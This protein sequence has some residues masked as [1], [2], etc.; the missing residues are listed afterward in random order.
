[1][2]R[3]ILFAAGLALGAPFLGRRAARA[4]AEAEAQ[5]VDVLLVLAVDVSRSI[6]EEEARLQREGYA[7]ALRSP[8]VHD[9]IAGGMHGAIG[10]AYVEWS[11]PEHQHLLLPWTRIDSPAAAKAA[12]GRLSAAPLRIGTWTSITA[13]LG[14]ARRL[15][16]AAPFPAGRLVIDVSGDGAN[17]A[18]GSMEDARDQVL[19]AGIV[20][21][22]LPVMKDAPLPVPGLSPSMPLDQYYREEVA[23]GFGAFVLPVEDFKGFAPAVRRK[24][25]LE[26]AGADPG[27][28]AVGRALA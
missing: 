25:I 15:I 26:I 7:E 10:L 12:A 5:A 3:R 17:N 19:A 9:A 13:A 21:N 28:L 23:G 14:H 20:I 16:A 22:G 6:D 11:G 1:M 2:R 18:G 4:D 24:L 8:A 27:G